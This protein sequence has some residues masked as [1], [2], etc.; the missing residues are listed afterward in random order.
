[1]GEELDRKLD[2]AKYD[3]YE[4]CKSLLEWGYPRGYGIYQW[5]TDMEK[6]VAKVEGN[7]KPTD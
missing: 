3:M 5:F 4:A 2:E 1:M 6:L 7:E